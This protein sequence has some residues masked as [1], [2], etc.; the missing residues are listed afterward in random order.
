MWMN[1]YEIETEVARRDPSTVLGKGA[2][3][4]Q[5]FMQE[6]DEHSDGWTYWQAPAKAANSLMKLLQNQ[7]ATEQQLKDAL[8]PIRG[9]MTRRGNKAGMNGKAIFSAGIAKAK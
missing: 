9:F 6:V 3:I 7:T 8:R 1:R 2:R 5:A 4:L